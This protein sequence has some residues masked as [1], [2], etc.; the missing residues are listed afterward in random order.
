M[1]STAVLRQ[2]DLKIDQRVKGARVLN[3]KNIGISSLI[4][5]TF[6]ASPL[7]ADKKFVPQTIGKE[8]I[9]Q[10]DQIIVQFKSSV[11]PANMDKSNFPRTALGASSVD[12]LFSRYN[13]TSL[14]KVF[15]KSQTP[16]AGSKEIDLSGFYLLNFQQ[17]VDVQS[18]IAEFGLD[19]NAVLAQ[20]VVFWPMRATPNDPNYTLQY[21]LLNGTH[22]MKA[23]NAWDTQVGDST[24]IFG[25]V[26][27]GINFR[28]PD[29]KNNIWVNPGEDINHNGVVFDSLDMNNLDDDGDGYADDLIGYDFLASVS[30]GCY[31]GEDCTMQ[32][33][34]P[35]DFLGH[36]TNLAGIVSAV[37]NNLQGGA[38]IG[39]GWPPYNPG[40]RLM[41]LR[42]GYRA[43]DGN[44]YV[45]NAAAA[46]A[47]YYA[48]NH[49]CRVVNYS[50]GPN[51]PGG[52]TNGYGF[53]PT[54]YAAVVNAVNNGVFI[55]R[56]AG[57]SGTECA[58]FIDTMLAVESV[59]AI[60]NGDILASFS[61][62]GTWIDLSA[63]GVGCYTTNSASGVPGYATVDGTS[64][65]SPTVAGVACLLASQQ[66]SLTRFDLD[67]LIKNNAD[68]IDIYNPGFVGKIGKRP[69]LQASMNALPNA[70]FTGGY[71]SGPVQF[72]TIF[73]DASPNSPSSWAWDFGDGQ[74]STDQNPSPVTYNTPGEYNVSLTITEPRGTNKRTKWNSVLVT[75]DTMFVTDSTVTPGAAATIDV[76]INLK[77]QFSLAQLQIPITWR[78]ATI[79]G[80]MQ[81]SV[82]IA[83]TRCSYFEQAIFTT[84]SN[85]QKLAVIKLK[86]DNGGGHPP[87]PPGNGTVCKVRFDISAPVDGQK[88]CVRDT[89]F[90]GNDL[91]LTHNAYIYQSKFVS[92]CLT[93]FTPYICGDAN[94]DLS[95][96]VS[97]AVFLISYIFGGG[98]APN[99]LA[100]GDA[101]CDGNTNI[102]D[103]VYLIQ[104]IFGGGPAPC[105]SCK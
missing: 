32:D 29:L 35:S 101:N 3:F 31:P 25:D 15:P 50:F 58:D 95:V 55:T 85:T 86:A 23:L 70:Q 47:T 99:P 72:T 79:T 24:I 21:W 52:C 51:P 92:G 40:V 54:F 22:G 65:S 26:D 91:A 18:A 93:A 4:V 89:S 84:L 28:H 41:A 8:T 2:S 96:N 64:F 17:P 10:H 59:A 20:P 37:T 71:V 48:A 33:R 88:L 62:R 56:A 66:P 102:S 34:D 13:V 90:S 36:G 61:E 97:D 1:S 43:A 94:G 82:V 12:A 27:S 81:S 67:T 105:A 75:A 14:Q 42:C 11:M 63:A 83:G 46:T 69:N 6:V 49:G 77:N 44:G 19:E 68:N 78:G 5:A 103:A 87:L 98:P 57:N 9:I 104:Y 80:T 7:V 39:G 100:A 73:A 45:N 16:P 76:A 74:T 38:G 30:N 60:D 53:D